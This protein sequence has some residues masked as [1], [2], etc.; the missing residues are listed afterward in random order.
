MTLL[1]YFAENPK[2]H[3]QW[4]FEKNAETLRSVSTQSRKKAWWRCE[5]GHEWQARIDSRIS[6]DRGCPCCAG[7]AVAKGENDFATVTPE[8][9][10]LWNSEKNG[11]LLPEDVMPGSRK[12]LWWICDKGHEWQ[13]PAYSIKAGTACP[14]CAGKSVLP[15]ENDLAT[16]HPHLL[17]MWSC[18]S[19][20]NVQNSLV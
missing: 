14:Y 16:T 11:K 9:L 5:K 12:R 2:L 19:L 18:Q 17:K 13:A 3:S 20:R 8:N 10:P 1:D 7:Q 15:G 6:L 4:A